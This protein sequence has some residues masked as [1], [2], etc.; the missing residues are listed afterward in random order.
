MPLS[1]IQAKV[2]GLIA[3]N[4]S[5][6]SHLAGATGILISPKSPRISHDLDLFHAS[7]AA[8]AAAY[9][10]DVE[11]MS[12]DGLAVEVL[13]SQPGF[14]RSRVSDDEDSLL[15]DWAHD[16]IWRFFETVRLENI[17]CV[18][19]PVDLAVNKVLA[20]VGRD[21]P[22]DF[23]DVIYV[24]ETVLPLKALIW[25][26]SGKDPGL[27]PLMILGLL[28]RK[29][30]IGDPEIKRLDLVKHISAPELNRDWKNALAEAKPWIEQRSAE[31]AGSLYLDPGTGR[32]FAPESGDRAEVLRPRAGG[33]LPRIHGVPATS[34]SESRE[35]RESLES[36]FQRKIQ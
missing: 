34:F 16:S 17:G 9:K 32:P 15:V 12:E 3:G 24:H 14:I 35:L 27:N 25:A 7:E 2:L 10:K 1:A 31:E 22:R 13:I 20:L 5:P 19:H 6:E 28:E 18:L 36:F 30:F 8:V 11:R 21:E 4:R 26:A 29:V 23:I 33:V